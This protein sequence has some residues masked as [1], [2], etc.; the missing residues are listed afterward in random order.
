MQKSL[1]SPRTVLAQVRALPL[2][3][4]LALLVMVAAIASLQGC[5]SSQPM[6]GR[7]ASAIRGAARTQYT[8]DIVY[9]HKY[10]ALTSYAISFEQVEPF[11]KQIEAS[12][13]TGPNTPRISTP[14]GAYGLVLMMHNNGGDKIWY[15]QL[16]NHNKDGEILWTTSPI[17]PADVELNQPMD[18]D[19]TGSYVTSG[20][21][22]YGKRKFTWRST[23][24]TP[25]LKA[26]FEANP[27]LQQAA[28]TPAK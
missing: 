15:Y 21:S 4:A 25:E 23:A 2:R 17:R 27:A 26:A 20:P 1:I 14:K 10:G 16:G 9:L 8:D 11:F 28:K 3:A 22:R 19:A 24:W 5:S 6:E 7:N 13:M 18:A 12:P